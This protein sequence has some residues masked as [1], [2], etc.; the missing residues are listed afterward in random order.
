[1][2]RVIAIFVLLIACI[3]TFFVYR[4]GL[5]GPFV[6]DDFPNIVHNP[7]IAITA[8]SPDQL[9]RA[10]FSSDSGPLDRPISMASFAVNYYFSGLNPYGLKLTNLIIHLINGIGIFI[11][12]ALL[13]SYVRRDIQPG[14]TPN[15]AIWLSLAVAAAWLLHPF[16]LTGV[17]YVVQRMT[18]LSALFCIY[19][20]ALFV[21]GRVR[22]LDGRSGG[23]PAILSSL[24][25]FTPLATLSKETGA[26]LPLF[27]LV[28]EFTLFNFRTRD[29]GPRRTLI[30]FYAVSVGLPALAALAYTAIHPEWVMSGYRIRDFDLPQRLMTEAR[31]MWFYLKQI[32]LPN[33]AAMGLFHDDLAVSRGLTQ[34]AITLPAVVGIVLLPVVA[35]A[36]RRR[37]PL[38]AFGV[39][40]YLAGH[41][42]ESTIFPLE[43]V[44]EHRNYLPMFGIVLAVFYYLLHPASAD[45]LPLRR[46]L[47]VAFIA[48]FAFDTHAR[49]R[50]WSNPF[51]FYTWEV[52][53]HPDSPRDNDELG[54][55]FANIKTSDKAEL[56]RNDQLA[57]NYFWRATVLDDNYTNGLFGIIT[58]SSA[59]HKALDPS[60]V[61]ELKKR[62][63]HAPYANDIGRHLTGLVTCEMNGACKFPPGEI[64]GLFDAALKNPTCRG[65]SRA[66]VYTAQGYYLIDIKKNYPAG[67]VAMQHMVDAAP[68][69]LQNRMT[70]AKYLIALQHFQAAEKQLDTI[71]TMDTKGVFTGEI[72]RYRGEIAR[73]RQGATPH[74]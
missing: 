31:V 52:R 19:G 70:L 7:A 15:K 56:A 64:E 74:R 62:L 54:N 12:S 57:M 58:L 4:P 23:L 69:A 55:V 27:M 72:A 40:F 20:L 68:R 61:V 6:F 39:L 33:T 32:L 24:V 47:A 37:A 14:L 1:M 22:L 18:S 30:V 38:L 44:F 25:V 36:L 21:W 51:D 28:I 34:P 48:L 17:L 5:H 26:L 45:T 63:E 11:L 43:L 71:A 3:A 9:W 16:N 73:E 13:L 67:L 53:H 10:A 2:Q 42:L 8:I 65:L 50:Q 29:P 35:V 49:A 66:T 41:L 60:W 59:R 46:V